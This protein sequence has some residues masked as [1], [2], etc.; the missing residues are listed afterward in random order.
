MGFVVTPSNR[1]LPEATAQKVGDVIVAT[2]GVPAHDRETAQAPA[3]STAFSNP[4]GSH[5]VAQSPASS[6][7]LSETQSEAQSQEDG[8]VAPR[9][10]QRRQQ[11]PAPVP[12]FTFPD[13]TIYQGQ[14]RKG[15]KH[16]YG[17]YVTHD[18]HQIEGQ[19]SE[20]HAVGPMSV[21]YSNGDTYK[22]QLV[23]YCRHGQGTMTSKSAGFKVYAVIL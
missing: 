8:P 6:L 4:A 21:K 23:R 15:K 16:G 1:M 20:G 9:T 22:G 13:G 18:G 17:V 7:A 14:M 19:W 2:A 10:V 11:T 12:F 5:D 3:A